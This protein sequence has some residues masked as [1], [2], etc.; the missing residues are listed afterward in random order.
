MRKFLG[1]SLL[2]AY[3]TTFHVNLA[4]VSGKSMI[5]TLNPDMPDSG[6]TRDVVLVLKSWFTMQNG[7]IVVHKHPN[8]PDLLLTKRIQAAGDA[9]VQARSSPTRVPIRFA[10]GQWI[11][12]PTGYLFVSSDE[13]FSGQDSNHFG[14]VPTGLVY[15][16]AV[17][18]VYPFNRMKWF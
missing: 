10:P 14:L 13:S 7:D 18:I 9:M 4:Q 11:H 15:G 12:V 2:I 1:G 5:P 3:L 8:Q 17:A 6:N 16:K